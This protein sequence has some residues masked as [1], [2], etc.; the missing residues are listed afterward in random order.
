MEWVGE[1]LDSQG[2]SEK[3]W[4][5]QGTFEGGSIW[6]GGIISVLRQL[7][8]LKWRSQYETGERAAGKAGN[9]EG[10]ARGR[11]LAKK[12]DKKKKEDNA[13][14]ISE[15]EKEHLHNIWT[16]Q[17]SFRLATRRSDCLAPRHHLIMDKADGAPKKEGE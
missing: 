3:G 16:E 11:L 9:R 2:E 15:E 12:N 14:V 5:E 4:E 10:M 7:W 6:K 17:E 13:E 1:M 8:G